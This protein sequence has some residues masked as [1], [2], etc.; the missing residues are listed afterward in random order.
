M[1]SLLA[2][3]CFAVACCCHRSVPSP[4]SL[5]CVRWLLYRVPLS[6]GIDV[7]W[8]ILARCSAAASQIAADSC[9]IVLS[10]LSYF[11][12]LFQL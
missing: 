7:H 8:A 2:S 12:I 10:A 1:V 5:I 4:M 3:C 6:T 11:L 9:W